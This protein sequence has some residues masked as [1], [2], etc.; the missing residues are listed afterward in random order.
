M[1]RQLDFGQIRLALE[2]FNSG[3]F[4]DKRQSPGG[5]GFKLKLHERDPSAPLS[6][7]YLNLRTPAN[8]KPG[9]LTAELVA[10]IGQHL[11]GLARGLMLKF[12]GVAGLPHAG[13]PLAEAFARAHAGLYQGKLTLPVVK[14]QKE[15][16]PGQ[17]R[18]AQV[19][20]SGHK[21]G[22][23]VLVIDDLI[24]KADTKLE[25]IAALER[26]GMK[27]RDVLVLLDRQ[28]GG[29]RQLAASG[30]RLHALFSLHDL[31]LCYLNQR[32]ITKP[33]YKEITEYLN[34]D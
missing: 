33:L 27:V 11:A 14:L 32:K 12:N 16:S 26:A 22:E 8:P 1:P 18:V 15:Q 9:P 5:R 34:A 24:T 28:Q 7:F 20:S 13:D 4:M 17:R 19:A 31:L 30:Y 21:P 6:P 25:G 10:K 3:A 23:V 2:I 29:A